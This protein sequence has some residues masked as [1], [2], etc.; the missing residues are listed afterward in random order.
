MTHLGQFEELRRATEAKLSTA[1]ALPDIRDN[2]TSMAQMALPLSERYRHIKAETMLVQNAVGESRQEVLEC[3]TRLLRAVS[4]LEKYGC[5]LT[6]PNRPKYWRSVKHNNPV[7][8]TTVDAIKGGREVLRIYGYTNQLPDGLSF[9][10]DVT[11]PDVKRV[12]EVTVEVMMLRVELDLLVKEAH[13]HPELFEGIL[14]P[15]PEQNVP[16]DVMPDAL[17]I[18]PQSPSSPQ[19]NP[20]SPSPA[21]RLQR[22]PSLPSPPGHLTPLAPPSPKSTHRC[23]LCGGAAV[24]LC[25]SCDSKPFCDAC[26]DLYH[27]HPDRAGHQ[28]SPIEETCG[29]CVVNLA[30][31]YCVTCNQRLCIECDRLYHSHPSRHSHNRQLV[32][33]TSSGKTLRHS[34]SSWECQRCTTVNDLQAVLCASCE[35][36]R[37]ARPIPPSPKEPSQ[38]S[39]NTVWECRS[40][41][42]VNPG[43]SVLC[44][45]CE[46]PRLATRPSITPQRPRFPP[47]IASPSHL[48]ANE[49][50]WECVHCTFANTRPTEVCE[51]CNLP[52]EKP[53]RTQ[54]P[55]PLLP[56]NNKNNTNAPADKPVPKP[57]TLQYQAQKNMK[58]EGQKLMN[59]I[60]EG[61]KRG[62]SPE[63]V[64]AALRVSRTS[65]VESDPFDWISSELPHLLDEICAMAVS[66]QQ[67]QCRMEKPDNANANSTNSSSDMSDPQV[68]PEGLGYDIQLSRVEAKQA[69]LTAGGN[70]E[71]AVQHLL[72]N[73]CAKMR[74]LQSMGFKD[75][76]QCE[77]ALRQSGGG[78]RGALSVLQRP[79]LEPFHQRIWSDQ[80]E[81]PINASDPDKQ[82]ICRRLLALYDLPSWGRCELA[83]SLLQ[84]PERTYALEDVIQAVKESHDRDLIK[85]MLHNTCTMC[86]S[87][88]PLNKMQSLTSCQCLICGECFRTHFTIAIRD[89]HIRDMVCPSCEEPDIN[90]PQHLDNYFST[91]DIQLRDCLDKDVYELFHQ[92]LTEH[93]LIQ[94]PKF[95][96]CTHCT[97]GF[98]YDG[99][100]PKV[101][102]ESCRQSFCAKCKKP[103]EDQ[104]DNVSCEDFQAWKRENDPE[105]QRQGLAGFLRDNGIVCPNCRFQYA[106]TRGG[107]MHFTCTQCRYEFCSGCNNPFH[108]R[109]GCTAAQCKQTGLHAHHPRDCLFYLRDW[110]PKRLQDLLQKNGVEFNTDPPDGTQ[111]GACRVL[112]QKNDDGQ[113]NDLPCGIQ[114][115]PQQA[116]LCDKHY[117][118]YLVSLINSHCLDPAPLFDETELDVVCQRHQIDSRP[119]DGEQAQARQARLLKKLME[120]PLGEKVPRKK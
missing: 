3:C 24:L 102:C 35:T 54:K 70:T 65:N 21:P 23:D 46:R 104:H 120:I 51:M 40:C 89:K 101:T 117:K 68:S 67:A 59:H 60:R 88:Y 106:L 97:N 38:P 22:A 6:N 81:A 16:E 52:R 100:Q 10:D 86:Y 50:Q 94:D 55:L 119:R 56:S 64:Y 8:R 108:K 82:R 115:H 109:G 47:T 31:A 61:E 44:T 71:K 48:E 66:V 99:N 12:A 18:P 110:E 33:H 77:A 27:R 26:D 76:A 41:T 112:E 29:I 69:W 14:P 37:L 5:N 80:P 28:R 43:S 32:S 118:E 87:N 111:T 30:S 62:V 25:A 36:P 79:L 39:S 78:I 103:W 83:L 1:G 20:F 90:D 73:R 74:E 92:K 114:T 42:V 17:V 2:V 98:I 84:E 96:W 15:L 113:P 11:E 45:V 58:E 91:L 93:A 107:C 63:E 49:N 7:F 9:P 53:S 34:L 85:R 75:R 116:G 4:I 13:P 72:R 57:R 105:Y 95:L 19:S